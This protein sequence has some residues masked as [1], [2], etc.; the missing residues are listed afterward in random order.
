MNIAIDND[1]Q[2]LINDYIN[3]KQEHDFVSISI[4]I[5]N[6]EIITYNLK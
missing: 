6:K 2:P 3:I 1:G 4:K 5:A